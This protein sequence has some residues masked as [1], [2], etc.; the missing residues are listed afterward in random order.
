MIAVYLNK[1]IIT[2]KF[3]RI[4]YSFPLLFLGGLSIVPF[5]NL[6]LF[7]PKFISLLGIA[8]IILVTSIIFYKKANIK[9]KL[10]LNN[11]IGMCIL[12]VSFTI[13]SSNNKTTENPTKN[14]TDFIIQKQLNQRPILIFNR[15]KP[16]ISFNLNKPV[17]ALNNGY[18]SLERDTQFEK[19]TTW[20]DF[21]INLKNPDEMEYLNKLMSKPSVLV[22]LTKESK[23]ESLN[24]LIT[25]YSNVKTIN[26]WQVYY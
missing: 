9:T 6:P 13:L 17:I 22:I 18:K 4:I 26:K 2:K 23:E 12:I 11:F 16:S 20:K 7:I 1:T 8:G 10:I 24:W 25:A 3:Q 5:L 14:I 15:F 21:F 19:D